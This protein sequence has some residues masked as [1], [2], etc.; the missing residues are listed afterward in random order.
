MLASPS[1]FYPPITK[2][3]Y[4]YKKYEP[5]FKEMSEKLDIEFIPCLDIETIKKLQNCLLVFDDS[6]EESFREK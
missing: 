2:T 4:F 6:C 5:V 3:Y 1:T